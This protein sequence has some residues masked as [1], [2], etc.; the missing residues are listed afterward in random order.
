MEDCGALSQK[1]RA[2]QHLQV[3][4]DGARIALEAETAAMRAEDAIDGLD[5]TA[6]APHDGVQ[7]AWGVLFFDQQGFAEEDTLLQGQRRRS[8]AR[9]TQP[10]QQDG[11]RRKVVTQGRR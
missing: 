1:S 11:A 3:E 4:G 6:T 8:S 10:V 5:L 2:V 7:T 9:R